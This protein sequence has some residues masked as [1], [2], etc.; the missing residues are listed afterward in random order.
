MTFAINIYSPL[1]RLY[2]IMIELNMTNIVMNVKPKV[3]TTL[4]VL[5]SI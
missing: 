3:L 1:S 2:V 5:P 4:R